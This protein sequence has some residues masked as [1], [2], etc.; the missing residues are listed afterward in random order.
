VLEERV[1]SVSVGAGRWLE[2]DSCQLEVSTGGEAG[3]AR[4]GTFSVKLCR[5]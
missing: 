2:L 3:T 5:L 1:V 4:L